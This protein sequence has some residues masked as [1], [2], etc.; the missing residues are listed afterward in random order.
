MLRPFSPRRFA[1]ID[2][3]VLWNSKQVTAL[4]LVFER[5]GLFNVDGEV[6]EHDGS[7]RLR[8]LPGAVEMLAGALESG[9]RI[10]I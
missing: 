2:R 3:E 8:V 10:K 7:L 1:Q 9:K 6:L 5:P 4:E